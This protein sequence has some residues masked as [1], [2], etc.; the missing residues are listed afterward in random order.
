MHN[1]FACAHAGIAARS[2]WIADTPTSFCSRR[3]CPLAGRPLPPVTTDRATLSGNALLVC[4]GCLLNGR[5]PHSMRPNVTPTTPL[6]CSL[7]G[8]GHPLHI[9][10]VSATVDVDRWIAQGKQ[11]LDAFQRQEAAAR[12]KLPPAPTAMDRVYSLDHIDDAP[13]LTHNLFQCDHGVK[14]GEPTAWI[15]DTATSM[16]ARPSCRDKR[17]PLKPVV[18]DRAKLT[19]FALLTC[20]ACLDA[21]RQPNSVRMNVCAD[22][23]QFCTYTDCDAQLRIRAIVARGDIERWYAVGRSW[24]AQRA[25]R[26]AAEHEEQLR[27]VREQDADLERQC[28]EL[29]SLDDIYLLTS[30]RSDELAARVAAA[31]LERNHYTWVRKHP[32]AVAKLAHLLSRPSGWIVYAQNCDFC[33]TSMLMS[34]GAAR[35]QF[36]AAIRRHLLRDGAP[37]ASCGADTCTATDCVAC[38]ARPTHTKQ[39]AAAVQQVI[40]ALDDAANVEMYRGISSVVALRDAMGGKSSNVVT[41]VA[42]DFLQ[43]TMA[44]GWTLNNPDAV[45]RLVAILTADAADCAR[46]DR[47]SFCRKAPL[48][49]GALDFAPCRPFDTHLRGV[50]CGLTARCRRPGCTA[51]Q[52]AVCHAARPKRGNK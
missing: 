37:T 19:G 33:A 51:Q 48:S 23:V 34:T 2:V 22:D 35:P 49:P 1:E 43:R 6:V 44:P 46:L 14:D 24:I 36:C 5:Q 20:A 9:R 47:C 4:H 13:V 12:A 30:G 11:R 31:W 32:D 39:A 28:A 15:A 29:D 40:P 38:R 25:E 45:G 41:R 17:R 42:S 7:A 52:C 26:D 3:N 18:T 10:V 27:I 16:C 8:C 21:G 50:S